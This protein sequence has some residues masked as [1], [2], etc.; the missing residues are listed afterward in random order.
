MSAQALDDPGNVRWW[1]L[2]TASWAGELERRVGAA[3]EGAKPVMVYREGGWAVEVGRGELEQGLPVSVEGAD[4]DALDP[5]QAGVRRQD[6]G[7]GIGELIA[8]QQGVLRRE[9]EAS[10]PPVDADRQHDGAADDLKSGFGGVDDGHGHVSDD[11]GAIMREAA[12]P[13]KVRP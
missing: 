4:A 13:G 8:D 2:R 1:V 10:W 6:I 3:G 7:A 11:G 12:A 9:G 5:R